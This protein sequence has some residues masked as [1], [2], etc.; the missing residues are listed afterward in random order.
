MVKD[1]EAV[2]SYVFSNEVQ[3]VLNA[4]EKIEELE[5]VEERKYIAFSEKYK[6]Q[7]GEGKANPFEAACKDEND[8]KNKFLNEANTLMEQSER[9]YLNY[10]SSNIDNLLYY[11]KYTKWADEY[12]WTTVVAQKSW[13]TQISTQIV[14]FRTESNHC[15]YAERDANTKSDSLQHFDDV[16]CKY[17]SKTDL[18]CFTITSQC[19]R[20]IG[21]FNCGGVEINMKQNDETNRFSGSVFIG[22]SKSVSVGKGP[23]SAEAEATA[24]V[25]IE[26]GENGKTDLV[27]KLGG[28]INVAGQTVAGVEA[29]AGVLSGPGISGKGM[30]QGIGN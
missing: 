29:R 15:K 11:R 30:L 22:A 27:G 2:D 28:N 7:F 26:L 13:L 24:A 18:G 17:I 3:P 10:V 1:I 14:K 23:F 25:G 20:L 4:A 16:A 12:A 8:I 19:S 21:E 9:V 6:D 5:K